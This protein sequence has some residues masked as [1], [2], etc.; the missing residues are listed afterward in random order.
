M[1][2]RERLGIEAG[3]ASPAT[4]DQ[5]PGEK[6]SGNGHSPMSKRA[7]PLSRRARGDSLTALE[8][9]KLDLHRKV[10]EAVD[11]EEDPD[12]FLMFLRGPDR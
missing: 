12:D 11:L 7:N 5:K 3:R 10:I 4:G 9:I 8:R 2:L 1:G 6:S